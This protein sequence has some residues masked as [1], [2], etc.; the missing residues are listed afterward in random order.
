MSTTGVGLS[1]YETK[2]LLKRPLFTAENA[3]VAEKS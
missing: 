3:E 2:T 1:D